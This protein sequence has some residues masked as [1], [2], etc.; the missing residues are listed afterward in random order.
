VEAEKGKEEEE[1]EE[2]SANETESETE[3]KAT[4]ETSG[5]EQEEA[6]P[7]S[8]AQAREE[9]TGSPPPE[10]SE[11]EN[12]AGSV[13]KGQQAEQ[14]QEAAP[15]T[16]AEPA[17]GQEAKGESTPDP[18]LSLDVGWQTL[19][20][21]GQRMMSNS[22]SDMTLAQR[23]GF[24]ADLAGILQQEL[25]YRDRD[26]EKIGKFLNC[27]PIPSSI[28]SG[29]LKVVTEKGSMANGIQELEEK[30][31]ILEKDYREAEDELTYR[32][33]EM[34]VLL[35]HIEKVRGEC[36]DLQDLSW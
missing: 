29:I 23:A 8:G 10:H 6:E 1:E 20:A 14:S 9:P 33:R 34:K 32:R 19:Q 17:G 4:P 2:E 31:V 25:H 18:N 3:E 13:G 5:K 35:Q 21:Q 30:K 12:Q 24:I 26:W 11:V 15:N 16:P 27:L 36:D 22:S 28:S 7:P